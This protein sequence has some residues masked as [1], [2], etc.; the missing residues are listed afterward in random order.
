MAEH[1]QWDIVSSVGLTALGVAVARALE[2]R[3]D[4]GLIQDPYAERLSRAAQP[5]GQLTGV[6]D[7]EPEDEAARELWTAMAAHLGVRSRFFDEY[8][9]KSAEGGVRQAVILASGLDA[10]PWRLE[11]PD[12]FRLFEIDQPQVI[13]FKDRVLA[14]DG[15]EARCKR[16]AVRADLRED[17]Q[18]ELL[19]AGFDPELPTAWLAEGLLPYLPPEAEQELLNSITRL[20]APGS[21]VAL[22][23]AATANFTEALDDPFFQQV[24]ERWGVDMQQLIHMDERTPAI[25]RLQ[26]QGWQVDW[27]ENGSTTAAEYGREVTGN[28]AKF[29]DSVHYAAAHRG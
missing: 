5:Q 3:D 7:A 2:T 11:W 4:N 28:G 23:H 25:S 10:R 16:F 18:S 12:D 9:R 13:D 17:W 27:D 19:S 15:A 26:E 29:L 22:E 1:E 21:R 20:S 14:E 6:L 24:S 8:F